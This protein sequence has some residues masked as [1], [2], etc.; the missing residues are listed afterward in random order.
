MARPC[1]GAR[2]RLPC[3]WPALTARRGTA[4][5]C[6]CCAVLLFMLLCGCCCAA[7]FAAAPAGDL[8]EPRRGRA[9]SLRARVQKS[10]AILV[11]MARRRSRQPEHDKS[12]TDCRPACIRIARRAYKRGCR[13]PKWPWKSWPHELQARH[14]KR[15][16]VP[17]SFTRQQENQGRTSHDQQRLNLRSR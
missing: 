16:A 3:R 17:K 5:Y 6:G 10:R 12:C 2:R 11:Y 7:C 15:N 1:S 13:R 9:S 4:R 14:I 8:H